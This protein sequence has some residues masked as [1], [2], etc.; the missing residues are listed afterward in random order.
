MEK[1]IYNSNINDIYYLNNCSIIPSQ[2]NLYNDYIHNIA[3]IFFKILD[4]YKI[5]YY[6]FAGSAI[7][8]IRNGKNIPWADD[9]DI[10]I[11]NKDYNEFEKIIPIFIKNGFVFGEHT[12]KNSGKY[13]LSKIIDKTYGYFQCDIFITKVNGKNILWNDDNAGLY[14]HK[15]I[16]YNLVHPPV[17]KE[18]DG[19]LLPF[20]NK[21][22]QDIEIEY[23]DI[24][25]NS[26]IHIRHGK[27]KIILSENFN[28][29]YNKFNNLKKK[30]IE[31]VKKI[32]NTKVE[33]NNIN[34]FNNI[35][36]DINTNL[37]E[38]GLSALKFLIYI[39][40]YIINNNCNTID[41]HNCEL[42]K[43]IPN[44]EQYIKNI[45][46]N[47]YLTPN[48]NLYDKGVIL[49]LN[50]V[51]NV[52]CSNNEQ[53]KILTDKDIIWY[54]KPNIHNKLYK[55]K[56]L[57]HILWINL[58]M[59]K[60]RYE[61]ML[62]QFEKYNITNHT[63][64]P[65]IYYEDIKCDVKPPKFKKEYA[66]LLSNLK[67]IQYYKDNY[68]KI[69]DKCIIVEDDFSFY[70]VKY[71]DRTITEYIS[72]LPKDWE[73]FKMFVHCL[74]TDNI[75]LNMINHKE[76]ETYGTNAYLINLK[77]CN[78]ILDYYKNIINKNTINTNTVN[79][80][81][82]RIMYNI[83]TTYVQPLFTFRDNNNTT[84]N[85]SL[86]KTLVFKKYMDDLWKNKTT[87]IV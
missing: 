82:D 5:N 27:D 83:C 44:V 61:H 79:V 4:K 36:L 64:I 74:D 17:Y 58:D 46:F 69:G 60:D 2:V 70:Y 29:T 48:F 30:G 42:L 47:I 35:K 62:N 57:P 50:Y 81:S 31:N 85:T 3:K 87:K 68:E 11:F 72:D 49:N 41:I 16:N 39:Q 22:E 37:N 80:C 9:Y 25:N 33:T 23:G 21:Y 51:A 14:V 53:Y 12:F 52:Y 8:L 67:A 32:L 77:S 20:F 59:S 15:E 63:R 76:K 73:I 66:C 40:N 28:I 78:K 54:N 34:N 71:W 65:A 45:T 24:I 13:I 7:G 1:L 84:L 55:L 56:N 19:I 26:I 6:V 18:F 38:Y 75:T 86:E 43:Y 10:I